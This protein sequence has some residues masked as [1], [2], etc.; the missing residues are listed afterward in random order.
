MS[1]GLAEN[2]A[3]LLEER[4]EKIVFAESCTAGMASALMARIP[5]ISAYLCGSFVTYRA[6]QKM[7]VLKVPKALIDAH[8]TESLEVASEMAAQAYFASREANWA[9]AIVGHLGP[10]APAEKDGKI[11]VAVFGGSRDVPEH[12]YIKTATFDLV[13]SSRYLRISEA[14]NK[15]ISFTTDAIKGIK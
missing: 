3:R 2:L 12:R 10:N 5:G 9:A 1:D 8:T 13:L 14:A 15:L 6:Q 4:D 7:D 11:Y